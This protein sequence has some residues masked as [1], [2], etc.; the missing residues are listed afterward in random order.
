MIV[1]TT[2]WT[3]QERSFDFRIIDVVAQESSENAR[4]VANK[5]EKLAWSLGPL[6]ECDKFSSK[7]VEFEL[8]VENSS[9]MLRK[10]LEVWCRCLRWE[11]STW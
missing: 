4:H 9:G 2:L 8:M 11:S 3:R 1:M 7:Y 10:H 6:Q 5:V